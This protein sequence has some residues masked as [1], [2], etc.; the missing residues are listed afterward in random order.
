MQMLKSG[1]IV[2][3]F[4]KQEPLEFVVRLW[5]TVRQ[6]RIKEEAKIWA[7]ATGRVQLS[8]TDVRGRRKTGNAAMN[9]LSLR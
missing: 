7:W 5:P 8:F 6:K 9:M 1:H 2:D 4:H 3:Q